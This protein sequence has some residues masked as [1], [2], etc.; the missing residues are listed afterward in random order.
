MERFK[1]G[2]GD[3]DDILREGQKSILKK[4]TAR[5]LEKSKLQQKP[6]VQSHSDDPFGVGNGNGNGP[7]IGGVD[8]SGLI[9]GLKPI[10]VVEPEKPYDPFGGMEQKRDYYVL[11][12]HY[13]HSWLDKARTDP[14]ITAGGYDVKEYYSRTMHEAFA[15]L[16]CFIADE[17][18]A[19]D[20]LAAKSTPT[21][22]AAIAA[23]DDDTGMQDAL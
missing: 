16:G 19:R 1:H 21:V 4:S 2:K 9:Q 6:Q 5:Q 17:V 11:Q 20:A 14:V 22:A 13:E 10:E 7:A 23:G 12:D 18:A 3:A 8:P 15:G